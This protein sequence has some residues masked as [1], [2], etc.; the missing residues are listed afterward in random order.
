MNIFD[1]V[2]NI[3]FFREDSNREGRLPF[4]IEEIIDT[5]LKHFNQSVSITERN[6]IP[7]TPQIPIVNPTHWI[8]IPDAICRTLDERRCIRGQ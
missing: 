4:S 8:K 6:E 5:E 2:K 3:L 7:D 1:D